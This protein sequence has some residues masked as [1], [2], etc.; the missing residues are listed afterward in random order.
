[1]EMVEGST[2]NS[3]CKKVMSGWFVL[4]ELTESCNET[5]VIS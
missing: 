4:G 2:L 5:M 1:M 3:V